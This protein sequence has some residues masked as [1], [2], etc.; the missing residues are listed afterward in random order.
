MV[1]LHICRINFP[2]LLYYSTIEERSYIYVSSCVLEK[3]GM[4]NCCGRYCH[5]GINFH[6]WSKYILYEHAPYH[7]CKRV[8]R[9]EEWNI[10]LQKWNFYLV[11]LL[12]TSCNVYACH[13]W[14]KMHNIS[15]PLNQRLHFRCSL[16]LSII[17]AH[18][19][20]LTFYLSK[21]DFY[22]QRRICELVPSVA[23]SDSF[24]NLASLFAFPSSLSSS[25][26]HLFPPQIAYNDIMLLK[27]RI[28]T[29]NTLHSWGR[30]KHFQ[31][32]SLS[33]F[34]QISCMQ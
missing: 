26:L 20:Q 34:H 13:L 15:I 14:L 18:I 25:S 11:P 8:R 3:H 24:N 12:L 2:Y 4:K 29:H 6:I 17:F 27:G 9:D 30:L 33:L 7:E 32:L 10:S 21:L 5:Y 23:S 31:G 16:L 1:A 22:G 28:F 19:K